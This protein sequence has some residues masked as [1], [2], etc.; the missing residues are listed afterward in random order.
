MT[1]RPR[2][3]VGGEETQPPPHSRR[4]RS[5]YL[6]GGAFKPDKRALSRRQDQV[7]AWLRERGAHGST[8]LEAPDQL[9]L[10]L[11]ARVSE[12]RKIGYRIDT[13]R[14]RV[15]DALMARYTLESCDPNAP[16]DAKSP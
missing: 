6:P 3:P 9:V 15:G 1:D 11:P 12:L 16:S 5:D 2:S 7:L 13:H 8:R 14:E 4:G 10:S